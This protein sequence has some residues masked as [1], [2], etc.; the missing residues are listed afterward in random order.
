MTGSTRPLSDWRG[1]DGEDDLRHTVYVA[2]GSNLGRRERNVTAALTALEATRGVIVDAV[3]SI[4]ETEPVGGPAGQERYLNC[5]ARLKVE[6]TAERLLHVLQSIEKSLGRMR[7]GEVR[8]GS[9]VI[10]LDLLLY[11]EQII[12]TP[13]LMVP[14]PLLHERRFVLEPLAEIAPDVVH[15]TM[16][17]TAAQLLAELARPAST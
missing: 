4:Y 13:E 16:S 17:R 5:V 14:H 15:P 11:G 10:D 1:F 7:E 8:W 3:S 9:R 12:S 6:L 2:V